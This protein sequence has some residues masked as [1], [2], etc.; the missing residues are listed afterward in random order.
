MK[1]SVAWAVER[2]E[3]LVN[4]SD[5]LTTEIFELER[6]GAIPATAL[7]KDARI[8]IERALKSINMMEVDTEKEGQWTP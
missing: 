7:A 4:I 1:R 5:L 6:A 8:S 2:W 3:K